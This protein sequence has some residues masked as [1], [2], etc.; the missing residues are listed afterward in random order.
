MFDNTCKFLAERFSEDFASWLLGKPIAMTNP[1]TKDLG[2]RMALQ[3]LFR[4]SQAIV[5]DFKGSGFNIDRHSFS[6][7]GLSRLG[8]A[9]E[10]HKS[11]CHGGQILL[12]Y[13]GVCAE[14][15]RSIAE[16]SLI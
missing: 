16:L 7:D 1:N 15:S 5:S 14:R 11:H 9:L 13:R 2:F 10:I 6:P 3:Q 4:N 8:N 12:C